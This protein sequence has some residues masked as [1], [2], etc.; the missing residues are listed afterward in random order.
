FELHDVDASPPPPAL[1]APHL[2]GTAALV[3]LSSLLAFALNL[4]ELWC[5]SAGSAM[6]LTLAGSLK[7]VLFVV[8]TA[9]ATGSP[10]SP[11]ASVGSVLA[12]FGVALFKLGRPRPPRRGCGQDGCPRPR[13]PAVLGS[14]PRTHEGAVD[15]G[16]D[17]APR[18][19]AVSE[20]VEMQQGLVAAGGAPPAAA[21]PGA[22]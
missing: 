20:R 12:A 7:T 2:A 15:V 5:I 14:L 10:L 16:K 22:G 13:H 1:Q 4:S 17:L 21:A 11:E 6:V 8:L 18:G 9:L 19:A 3:M